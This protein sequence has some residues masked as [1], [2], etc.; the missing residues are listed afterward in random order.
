MGLDAFGRDSRTPTVNVYFDK[1][2]EVVDMV[3]L[4]WRA[5]IDCATGLLHSTS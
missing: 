3:F 4:F 2:F 1:N 5:F